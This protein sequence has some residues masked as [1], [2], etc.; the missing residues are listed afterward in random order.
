MNDP[1][2]PPELP[3]GLPPEAAA[4]EAL[5][6]LQRKICLMWGSPELDVFISRLIMDSRDGQRQGLPVA[7][8]T[9]LLFLAQT[10]KTIRAMALLSQQNLTLEEAY[11]VV[12]EGDQKRL[13]VDTLDNPLVSHDM[14]SHG[15]KTAIERRSADRRY[16]DRRSEDRG[17]GDRRFGE[18]R[19][20]G[21]RQAVKP[22]NPATTLG[23]IVFG[24]IFN[25]VL[26]F[27]IAFAI[28]I[29][30]LWPYFQGA[31]GN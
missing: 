28:A 4:L 24:L 3:P 20:G 1:Q 9:E 21:N 17:T 8:A 30:W 5:G 26:I 15:A 23:Q 18:R 29:K 14:I 19:S 22:E 6:H 12:D 16:G 2:L 27:L 11:R 7:A 10:N 13:E 31:S 25:K